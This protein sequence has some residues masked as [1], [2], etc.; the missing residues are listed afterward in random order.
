MLDNNTNKPIPKHQS[1]E[2]LNLLSL[3]RQSGSNW[4]STI[5]EEI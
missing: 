5:Q 3:W 2:D 1:L 4:S